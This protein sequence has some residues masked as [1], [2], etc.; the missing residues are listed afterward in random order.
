MPTENVM[1]RANF[2]FFRSPSFFLEP[3]LNPLVTARNSSETVVNGTMPT[4]QD[5]QVRIRKR[6]RARLDELGMTAR[7]LA[8]AVGHDDAWISGVLAGAHGLH[9][10]DFDKVAE[11][12]NLSPSELVRHNDAEVRELTP[13]EMRLLRHYQAW[14]RAMQ[15]KWLD[16]LEHFSATTPDTETAAF[17]ER[18]RMMPKSIRRPVLDWMSRLLEEGTLPAGLVGGGGSDPSAGS[19]GPASSHPSHGK[20]TTHGV[21]GR[22]DR[23]S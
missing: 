21:H 6:V 14:P 4:R 11:K 12:L 22:G 1:S 8:R 2:R 17:L 20:G 13:S 23:R 3:K 10:K 18:L 9:W 16:L 15:Q 7:E 19:S 5:V